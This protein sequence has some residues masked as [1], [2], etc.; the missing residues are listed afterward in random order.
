MYL[1]VLIGFVVYIFKRAWPINTAC[2]RVRK[3]MSNPNPRHTFV[4]LISCHLRIIFFTR[5]NL[6]HHPSPSFNR[7]SIAT[8]FFS[9]HNFIRHSR[10]HHL[11]L[12]LLW[13]TIWKLCSHE[14]RRR[15]LGG[16]GQECYTTTE[17]CGGESVFS[18]LGGARRLTPLSITPEKT[19]MRTP[20]RLKV[21]ITHLRRTTLY[22]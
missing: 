4:N 11:Y 5:K 8:L 13:S 19:M 12:R 20:R 14:S 10:T 21:K 16:W 15:Q 9:S 2:K 6:F 17:G 3:K 18:H 1:A 22:N 7:G